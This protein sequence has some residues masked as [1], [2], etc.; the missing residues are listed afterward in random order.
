[1]VSLPITKEPLWRS[2]LWVWVCVCERERGRWREEETNQNR[3]KPHKNVNE[4]I[5]QR[6]PLQ[7]GDG[8]I[9][10]TA[11]AATITTTTILTA[12]P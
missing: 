7:L 1:M 12:K 10:S 6:H 11:T 2:G 5:S 4:L 3:R 8:E 9:G